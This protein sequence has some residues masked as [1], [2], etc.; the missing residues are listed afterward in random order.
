MTNFHG[1]STVLLLP[2]FVGLLVA[3]DLRYEVDAIE[4][5]PAEL[6]L[7]QTVADFT[8]K[9]KDEKQKQDLNKLPGTP[10]VDY[11]LFSE[12]PKTSFSCHNVPAVPG[13]YANVETGCQA[14][15]VCHDGREGEQ[16][17]SF[18]CANGTIFNQKEFNCDWWY[19][20]DCASAP[21]LYN[22]NSDP[23]TNPYVPQAHKERIR[24][25]RLRIVIE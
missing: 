23:E 14:Y 4:V 22:L 18:L 11:P 9:K 10:W 19:N 16:G 12:V 13:I 8:T 7:L 1:F 15:H 17:A 21:V 24:K 5:H 20:V 6:S 25:E 3:T 2:I